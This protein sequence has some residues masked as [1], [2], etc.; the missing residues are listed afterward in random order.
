MNN[1]EAAL[2][3]YWC[4]ECGNQILLHPMNDIRTE[5]PGCGNR[6]IKSWTQPTPNE[7]RDYAI[8]AELGRRQDRMQRQGA[9]QPGRG[10]WARIR[11]WWRIR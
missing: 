2:R 8:A 10:L 4:M 6:R 9:E 7:V 1:E 11:E 3:P 5:C